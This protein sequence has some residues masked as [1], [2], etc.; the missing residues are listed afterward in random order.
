MKGWSG[1]SSGEAVSGPSKNVNLAINMCTLGQ[2]VDFEDAEPEERDIEAENELIQG[3]SGDPLAAYDVDVR[4][5]GKAI[6]DYLEKIAE[7]QG[8]AG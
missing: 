4:E 6:Q 7:L 2:E 3:V 8:L 5:E 1:A